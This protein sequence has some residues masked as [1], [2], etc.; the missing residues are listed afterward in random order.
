[1]RSPHRALLALWLGLILL[2]TGFF[3][4]SIW[5][6]PG[7]TLQRTGFSLLLV[8]LMAQVSATYLRLQ[9]PR[10]AATLT[11]IGLI[12]AVASIVIFFVVLG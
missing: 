4:A 5:A 8:S 3:L 6:Q 12:G 7:W 10:M 11:I 2:S 1:M 9:L